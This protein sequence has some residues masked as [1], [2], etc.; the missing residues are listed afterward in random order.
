METYIIKKGDTLYG[1]SK[2]YGVSVVDL[3][4]LNNLTSTDLK[5]GQEI[6]IPSKS[7]T[8]PDNFFTYTVKQGDSLY[9]IAKR[10]STTPEELLKLNNLKTNELQINQK[11]IVPENYK[12]VEPLPIFTTYT[13]KQGD[14][15]YSIAKEFNTTVDQIIKDNNLSTPDL[16]INQVLNIQTPEVEEVEECIGE[17]YTTPSTSTYKVQKGDSIYSIAKKFNLSVDQIKKANNLSSN[18]LKIDQELIIG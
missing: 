18:L 8:S 2:Q 1:I 12:E 16:S 9:S 4:K 3:S 11:L 7:G 14:N 15:L 10:Y 17:E 6:K 5:I 13:V